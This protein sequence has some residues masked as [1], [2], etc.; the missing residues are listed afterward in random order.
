MSYHDKYIKYK[1]KYTNSKANKYISEIESLQLKGG[2]VDD[3]QKNTDELKSKTDEKK[4]KTD[5]LQSKKDDLSELIELIEL[6]ELSKLS[7]ELSTK[8]KDFLLNLLS[9]TKQKLNSEIR[10]LESEYLS[11][12]KTITKLEDERLNLKN[13]NIKK[14]V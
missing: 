10:I 12:I 3:L 9:E 7:L 14:I 1:E 13:E 5:E 6:I 11:L 8:K 4:R 2:G